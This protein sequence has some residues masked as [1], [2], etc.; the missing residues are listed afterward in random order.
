MTLRETLRF[1]LAA[2]AGARMRSILV[3]VAMAIGVA[4][5]VVLTALGEGARRYVAG[6]FASLGTH[7]LIVLPGRNETTGGA[8]PL[9]PETPRDLTLADALALER[10]RYVRQV[11][12]VNVGSAPV[13]WGTREREVLILGSTAAMQPIRHMQLSRGRFLPPGDV[14]RPTPVCVIGA[15]VREEL[16]GPNRAL[17]EWLRV[18]D[19][20]FRVIGVL[21]AQG[22]SLGVDTDDMVIVPVAFAQALFDTESLFR[23]LVEARD[24]EAVALAKKD[25]TETLRRRHE[26][27]EDVTVITQDS[28]LATFDRILRTLTY[29]V[30][31]IAGVSLVVAGVLI[32]NVMLVSVS[33]RTPEVGLLKAVGAPARQVLHLFLAEAAVLSLLGGVIGLALG[34]AGTWL[35]TELYPTLP[36]R[37]PVWAVGAALGVAVAT[38]TLFG[39]LP[40]R[41]AAALDPVEA[42]SRH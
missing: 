2:V 18:G 1:A 8:P 7:L 10:S 32:M 33:Q 19:R 4:A 38:G 36:F 39:V 13:T 16:F 23:I 9:L 17:G 37:P 22:Q 30:A 6:E 35:L 42:L 28:V 5:V 34:G 40:A 21:A 31:G 15:T 20:R 3:L 24:R 12:P 41:R 14:R 29:T 11:A 27:E 26:G 25:V